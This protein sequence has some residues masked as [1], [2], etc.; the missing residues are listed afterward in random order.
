MKKICF[1]STSPIHLA[2]NQLLLNTLKEKFDVHIAEY[3]R[4]EMSMSEVMLDIVPKF[5]VALDKIKPDAILARGDRFEILSIATLAAYS[6]IPIIHIEG[7]DKSGLID[8]RVRYAVSYLSDWH[9]V[10]NEE[11]YRRAI[12]MDF[13]NVWNY[14]SLDCEYALSVKPLNLRPK[15][16]IMAL[17]HGTPFEDSTRVI[18]AC[19]AFKDRFDIVGIRGNHDYGE[20][21]IYTESYPPDEFINLL[22]GASCVVG[23]SSCLIKEASV[24]GT[25]A[26]LVGNRQ[27][28]RL[29]TKNILKVE[30]NQKEIEQAIRYQIEH[31]S[32]SMDTTY[33]QPNTAKQIAAKITEVLN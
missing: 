2:R 6:N 24:L 23:N 3:G 21:S 20:K 32:Y 31:G 16:V 4:K 8:Q 7:F 15:R 1:P 13:K 11:S 10:T 28:N 26:I 19:S 30:C 9:F 25:P 17:W 27:A 5:K 12:S 29:L 22:R 18:S 14:G 33:Y